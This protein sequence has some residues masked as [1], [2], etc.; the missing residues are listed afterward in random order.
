MTKQKKTINFKTL[1]MNSD[2]LKQEFFLM[3]FILNL[4]LSSHEY[5]Q[6]ICKLKWVSRQHCRNPYYK[7]YAAER[8][9]HPISAVILLKSRTHL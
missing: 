9:K 2:S 4:Y 1:T 3:K 8:D 6:V 5:E 7:S